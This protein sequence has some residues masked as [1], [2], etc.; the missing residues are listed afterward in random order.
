MSAIALILL[1]RA[2]HIVAGFIWAGA[3]F[4]MATSIMPVARQYA[5]EGAG[6]WTG[7]IVRRVGPTSGI[8]AILTILSGMYLF[9]VLHPGDETLGGTVLK[10]GAVAGLLSFLIG[11]FIGR[12]AAFKLTALTEQRA[13]VPDPAKQQEIAALGRRA[14]L[15][16]QFTMTLLALA[17]LAMAVFRYVQALA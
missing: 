8:A 10:A 6:R 11:F 16:A 12:P 17:V 7:M 4:V 15:S 13:A 3:M 14:A 2:I 1:A 9:A 5:A